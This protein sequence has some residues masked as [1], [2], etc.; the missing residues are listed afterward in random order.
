MCGLQSPT[1]FTRH[2][3]H[4]LKCVFEIISIPFS[5]EIN[6]F[7]KKNSEAAPWRTQLNRVAAD[8]KLIPFKSDAVEVVRGQQRR[9][10]YFW[11][12][13]SHWPLAAEGAELA[14]C[15][16][17]TTVTIE[18]SAA[19]VLIFFFFTFK[20]RIWFMLLKNFVENIHDSIVIIFLV[21]LSVILTW[22][23]LFKD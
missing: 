5:R 20:A 2:R 23:S 11:M 13:P 19:Q 21:E 15:A 17:K 3:I 10:R 18:S 8:S 1:K 9:G 22:I 14:R 16:D 12:P 4:G 7:K 6:E